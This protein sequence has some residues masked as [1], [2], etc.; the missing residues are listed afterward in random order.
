MHRFALAVVLVVLALAPTTLSAQNP[1]VIVGDLF[2][3]NSYGSAGDIFA[4]SVGTESCNIGNVTL[5]WVAGNNLHPVIGQEMWRLKDGVLEQ[6]GISWL[7]HSF[8][9]LDNTFCGP[10]TVTND[11][12]ILGI[13]CSDPYG[14]GLNGSQVNLGPRSQVNASTGVFPYPFTAPAFNGI[15]ARRLQVHEADLTAAEN[16]GAQYFVTSHYVTQDDAQGGNGDNNSSYRQITIDPASPNFT[17]GMMPGSA[18]QQQSPGIQAWQDFVPTVS[19]EDV[20]VPNDGLIIVGNNIT[21]NG[22][23]TWHYEYAVY[24]I[25]SDRCADRLTVNFPGVVDVT[26]ISMHDVDHHSGEPYDGTDWPG[27]YSQGVGVTW[28]TTPF[29]TNQDANA[30]RWSTMYNFRFDANAPPASGTGSLGIFKPGTPSAMPLIFDVPA[31]SLVPPI[32]SFSCVPGATTVNL[33]W[34]NG[35]VYDSIEVRRDGSLLATLAGTATGFADPSLAPGTYEWSLRAFQGLDA[36]NDALCSAAVTLRTLSISDM[37]AFSGQSALSI[38]VLSSNSAPLQGFTFS[39]SVPSDRISVYEVSV[40]GT[41][42]AAAGAEFVEASFGVGFATIQVV[43]D[44]VGPFAQQTIGPGTDQQ[45]ATLT[46]S[47]TSSHGS[48]ISPGRVIS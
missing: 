37:I 32:S 18:T 7:K 16:A 31:G 13:G 20:Q 46:A 34:V 33:S 14:A 35:D 47:V 22:N 44:A 45:I 48:S 8:C 11:C 17:A 30:I 29:G 19:L 4:Y 10:C 24:N 23:G 27:N 36:T 9:A 21:D 39:I 26:N 6:I 3:I 43:L 12:D 1:D 5:S 40:D 41:I 42:T 2:N 25:N 15:I 28:Q 38:P